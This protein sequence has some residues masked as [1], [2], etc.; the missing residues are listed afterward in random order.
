MSLHHRGRDPGA[1]TLE[2]GPVRCPH[3]GRRQTQAD[4]LALIVALLTLST[5]CRDEDVMRSYSQVVAYTVENHTTES[6]LVEVARIVP[7]DPD[8]VPL[9]PG[10]SVVL[11]DLRYVEARPFPNQVFECVSVRDLSGVLLYQDTLRD[12]TISWEFRS[13][14]ETEPQY[15]YVLALAPGDLTSAGVPDSCS[16]HRRS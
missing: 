4:R 7:A 2:V 5:G 13:L 3:P 1:T 15:A 9:A 12:W 8:V 10:S 14:G 6:L 11:F 16:G